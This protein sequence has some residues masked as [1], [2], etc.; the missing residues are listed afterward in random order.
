MPKDNGIGASS[1][2]RED[3]R[4]LTGS[5]N[6]T[7]DINVHGQAY[8]A[9]ARSNVANGKIISLDTSAAEGLDGVLAVFTGADFADVG[10]NPA[11]WLINSRDGEPMK[12]PKRPVLAHGKVR[13][14]GDAYAA[15]VAETEEIARDAVELISANIEELPA[16]V[17]LKSALDNKHLVHDEI[18][19][20]QCF[21]WG[22][23]ED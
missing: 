3:F 13:H 19:T 2:R 11:G 22:W 4:F 21:D 23:I 9:F 15:V 17:D 6:Y 8:V 16:V 14:V 12:E 7:D 20:N 18:E 10:G 1:L 5:G